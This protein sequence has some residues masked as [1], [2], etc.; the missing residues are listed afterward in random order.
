VL[1]LDDLL[2]EVVDEARAHR[3]G[4]EPRR[5]PTPTRSRR[6]SASARSCSTT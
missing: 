1:V 4:E 6:P 5:C 3:A 2:D